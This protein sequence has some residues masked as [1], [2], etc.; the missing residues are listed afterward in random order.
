MTLYTRPHE[1]FTPDQ[2]VNQRT[3][4]FT[5]AAVLKAAETTLLP[6]IGGE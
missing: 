5:G 1:T 2:H 6:A 4:Q 3:A